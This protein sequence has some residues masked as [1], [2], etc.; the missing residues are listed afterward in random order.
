MT[1]PTNIFHEYYVV[2][3][4][5]ST[6][7]RNF[8]RHKPAAQVRLETCDRWLAVDFSNQISSTNS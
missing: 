5:R 6:M 1:I 7:M 8:C 3:V 2:P 4:R